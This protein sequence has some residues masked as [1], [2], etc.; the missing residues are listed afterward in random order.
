MADHCEALR[1][2]VQQ[3]HDRSEPLYIT[4]GGSKRHWLGR[5]CDAT[6]L[7]VSAHRGVIDYQPQELVITARSG[8]PVNE[9]EALLAREGQAL[10]FEPPQLRDRATLGGT[11]ACNLSGPARPWRGA[12]RDTVLGAQLIDGRGQLLSFGGQ[13]MKNVAG[14]DIS[15]LQA[16]AQ[17]CLGLLT[18]ISLKVLPRPETE[19]TLRYELD[20]AAAIEFMNRSAGGSAPLSG[21]CWYDG[22]CYLRLQGAEP[23]VQQAANHLGG[24]AVSEPAAPWQSLRELEHPFFAGNS[25]LWRASVGSAAPPLGTEPTLVDWGGAQRWLRGEVD[26]AELRQRCAA[27]GGHACLFRGGDRSGNT[28]HPLPEVSRRLHQRLKH[29]FDP[30]Q[31]F[32]PGRLYDWL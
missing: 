3:A 29:S 5:D 15:R 19:L 27:A 17:G 12:A 22:R 26:A 32:N 20:Q 25:P 9:V 31:V 6:A 30:G 13:V 16:G 4:A 10:P 14:Y 11:I 28:L 2:S 21:A 18:S 8:T 1:E 7:D 24:E 23:A